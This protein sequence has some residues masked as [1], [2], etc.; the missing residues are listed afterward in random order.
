MKEWRVR[1]T[2]LGREVRVT[3]VVSG[4]RASQ[5]AR[6]TGDPILQVHRDFLAQW[7]APPVP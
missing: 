5:L 7:P 2:V 4:F 6:A 1:F 3:R